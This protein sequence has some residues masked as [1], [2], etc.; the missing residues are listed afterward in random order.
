MIEAAGGVVWRST[1][2]HHVEVLLI[3][4]PRRQD[5]SL[6]KG[7]MQRGESVLECAIREV[8]EETGMRGLIGDELAET[9]Y[10]DR[11]GRLKQVRYWSMHEPDGVFRPN[12]EVDEIRWLRLDRVGE[13]LT[14]ER[15]ALVVAG[16][17]RVFAS[18]A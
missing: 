9:R 17:D 11:K 13:L 8:H 5:W 7:K 12:R 15:D 10:T 1:S 18:V 14:Y 4:R 6:P 2:I 16:L 3:H